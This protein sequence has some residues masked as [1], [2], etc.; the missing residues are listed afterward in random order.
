MGYGFYASKYSA[1]PIIVAAWSKAWTIFARSN[2]G[3]WVRIQ[4]ETWMSVCFYSVFVLFCVEEAALRWA[5]PP[6]KEFYWLFIGLR[7]W[8]SGQGPKGCRA[9][10][11]DR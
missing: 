5:D 1:V 2:T 10:K 11:R 9:I 7:S 4:L 3:S 6:S 8:K